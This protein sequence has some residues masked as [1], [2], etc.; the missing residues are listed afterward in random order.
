VRLMKSNSVFDGFFIKSE[1]IGEKF[2]LGM[3]SAALF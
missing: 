3:V 1:G 2:D